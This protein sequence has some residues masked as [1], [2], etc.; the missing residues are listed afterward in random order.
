MMRKTG[1]T[2]G[3]TCLAL[4]MLCT[5]NPW[6]GYCAA[7]DPA[8]AYDTPHL[9]PGT[10]GPAIIK[11][12]YKYKVIVSVLLVIFLY[13][14]LRWVFYQIMIDYWNVHPK[15]A[16]AVFYDT[17]LLFIAGII[18]VFFFE[19]LLEWICAAIAGSWLVIA[20][21]LFIIAVSNKG[22]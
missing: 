6:T 3:M 17:W 14:L 10:H 7:G 2:V 20:I 5:V 15:T 11:M 18:V 22:E 4:L 8:P 1:I 9:A 16:L 19:Y 12:E 13:I 21:L